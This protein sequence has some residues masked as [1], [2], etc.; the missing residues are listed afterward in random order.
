MFCAD[1]SI[2]KKQFC[3]DIYEDMEKMIDEFENHKSEITNFYNFNINRSIAATYVL[4]N[5]WSSQQVFD[6]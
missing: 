5:I 3:N 1:S 4:R 6:P 2:S